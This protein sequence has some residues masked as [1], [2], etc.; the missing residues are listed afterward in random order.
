MRGRGSDNEAPHNEAASE[1]DHVDPEILTPT[2]V[3]QINIFRELLGLVKNDF[4]TDDEL[5]A[6]KYSDDRLNK[7]CKD[8]DLNVYRMLTYFTRIGELEQ[9]RTDLGNEAY[10]KADAQD[11]SEDDENTDESGKIKS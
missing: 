1:Q 4:F 2:E 10:V 9:V 8:V 3:E 11:S 6:V 5:N 7:R